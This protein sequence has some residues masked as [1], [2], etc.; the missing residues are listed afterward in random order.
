MRNPFEFG[1]ELGIGE[2]VDRER[3]V[4]SVLEAIR[5]GRKLFLIGPRRYGKTSILK[6]AEDR[7]AATDAVVLRFDAESY[8]SL[9][10]LVAGIIA[11]SAKQLKSGIERAGEQVREFFSRLRPQLD[12]SLN[13]GVWTAKLGIDPVDGPNQIQLLV[14]ALDGLESLAR[15]QPAS[16]PVGLI[17]DEFQKIVEVGGASAEAQI[18]AAIQRHKRTGYVFAGS[19]TKVLTA[20][21]LDASRPFYRLGSV[22]FIGPVPRQDFQSFLKRKFLEGGFKVADPQ[23]ID[24]ILGF[25]EEVPYNVQMLASSCWDSLRDHSSAKRLPLT[26]E[27]VRQSVDRLVRQYDPFYTQLWS[28]LTSIQQKTVLAVIVAEGV[29]LQSMKVARATGTGPSTVR[30]SLD[31]LIAKSVLREEEQGGRVRMRFEDPFFAQW[32]RLVAGGSYLA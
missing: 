28:S 5:E 22:C 32:V 11:K 14:D 9:D 4:E 23:A 12:F 7:L 21:T 29:N 2:L 24:E 16:R 17:L 20:M 13:D 25:A 30:K 19:K 26:T 18:R 31:A 3:E 27:I 15:A 8:P 1:R 10:L 6:A